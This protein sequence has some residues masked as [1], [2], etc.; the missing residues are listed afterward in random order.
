M[1]QSTVRQQTTFESM[2][3]SG[4]T[5][6]EKATN[7]KDK[8]SKPRKQAGITTN[9]NQESAPRPDGIEHGR[10]ALQQNSLDIFRDALRP[11]E[12]DD[13]VAQQ[14]KGHL[15]Q[16]DFESAFG[17]VDHLRVYASRWSPVRALA[18][19]ELLDECVGE[20]AGPLRVVCLGG[21]AG[22]ELVALAAWASSLR[23]TRHVAVDL[24]D[25]A[26]WRQ[27]TATLH[28]HATTPPQLSQYASRARQASN[29]ALVNG[30][31]FT[32]AF[33][34]LNVLEQDSAEPEWAGLV[35]R[36]DLVTAM[37]TVNELYATSLVKTQ[38]LLSGAMSCL[39]PGGKLL[40]VDSPGSYST[41]SLN[42][43]EKKYPMHWLLDHTLI[44]CGS[45][46]PNGQR[47]WRKT[48]ENSSRW[49]RLPSELRYPVPLQDIR[50][51]V[52]C[53]RRVSGES[54]QSVRD[55]D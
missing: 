4:M 15:Y 10:R 49:F 39:R 5:R 51:Q 6:G 35:G 43:T 31:D 16:R 1:Q 52:H 40:V 34:R 17:T 27:V 18:Y 19:R 11:S 55:E 45:D 12:E 44:R 48:D 9:A 36:A 42:G 23:T 29:R 30:E 54:A 26:D 7:R 47:G 53:Y 13:A 2:Q 50:F 38:A 25:M 3:Q 46:E 8:I 28:H 14:V 22:S 24:V 33:H 41:V 32:V 21:G 20:G 37:F